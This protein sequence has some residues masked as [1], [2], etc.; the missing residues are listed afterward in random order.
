MVAKSLLR[1]VSK[2]S[3]VDLA[4]IMSV[5]AEKV[6][7]TRLAH[8]GY[9]PINI[10][11]LCLA[12][13]GVYPCFEILPLVGGIPML[14]KRGGVA[15]EHG[16][17]GQYQ[18]PGSVGRISDTP[19]EIIDRL[20]VEIFG[21][22]GAVSFSDLNLAGVNIHDEPERGAVCW[23]LVYT[24]NIKDVLRLRGDWISFADISD[25]RIIPHHRATLKWITAGTDR[26]F[27]AKLD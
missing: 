7:A 23:S 6:R 22:K 20:S 21:I 19:E 5:I 13:G 3:L 4:S 18:I 14:K 8:G 2:M 9:V 24:L 16:W 10:F 12:I 26:V 17:N 25:S 1:Q 27:F 11:P 15:E